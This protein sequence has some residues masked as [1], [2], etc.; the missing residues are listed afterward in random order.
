[1]A[2]AGL[3]CVREVRG[4]RPP[5]VRCQGPPSES[6][7]KPQRSHRF[8]ATTFASVQKKKAFL[9][10][11]LHDHSK[12]SERGAEPQSPSMWIRRIF[13]RHARL[14]AP[15]IVRELTP[16]CG[17]AVSQFS[18]ARLL[19]CFALVPWANADIGLAGPNQSFVFLFRITITRHAPL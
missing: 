16:N 4:A 2:C 17:C 6:F 13:D 18:R 15:H 3:L 10:T 9:V 14:V 11:R 7:C 12:A 1:M 8:A 5:G 19:L